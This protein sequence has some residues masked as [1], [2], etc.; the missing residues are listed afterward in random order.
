M[1]P[2]GE[3]TPAVKKKEEVPGL[4]VL[5]VQ[6]LYLYP[7]KNYLTE[8]AIP[9]KIAEL[10]CKEIIYTNLKGGRYYSLGFANNKNGYI[11][12]NKN[13]KATTSSAITTIAAKSNN[14]SSEVH[15]NTCRIYE[16]FFNFL[17]DLTLKKELQP[18]ADSIILNSTT[19]LVYS[20]DYLEQHKVVECYLD[21]DNTGRKTLEKIKEFTKGKDIEIR[22]MSFSYHN[23]NDLND[24]L[25]NNKQKLSLKKSQKL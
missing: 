3:I 25:I 13:F 11:L 24:Y 5:N 2:T 17:S 7:L 16:G 1:L 19:N 20:M 12:R 22:D 14:I 4:T 15:S 6:P 21:N 10:Y 9:I 23:H 8:R 18:S